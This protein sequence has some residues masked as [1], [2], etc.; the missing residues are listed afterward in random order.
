V[1]VIRIL[2][3]PRMALGVAGLQVRSVVRMA[4]ERPVWL[5]A[6]DP[7]YADGVGWCD[8]TDD[9]EQA[10]RFPSYVE[11]VEE[12]RRVSTVTPVR[13]DGKPNRPL[14]AY[15]VSIENAPEEET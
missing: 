10:K 13:H 6:Y 5:R 9:P 1:K 15:T 12:Y 14:T 11:A 7:D 4:Q 2:D 8:F 3:S